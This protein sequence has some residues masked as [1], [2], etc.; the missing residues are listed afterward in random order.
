MGEFPFE[1]KVVFACSVLLVV[2]MIVHF[3]LKWLHPELLSP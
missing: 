3:V 2:L 1:A